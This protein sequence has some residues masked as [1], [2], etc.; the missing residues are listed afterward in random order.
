MSSPELELRSDPDGAKTAGGTLGPCS[1]ARYSV[2]KEESPRATGFSL[3]VD[4]EVH[5]LENIGLRWRRALLGKLYRRGGFF[6][7]LRLDGFKLFFA[8]ELFCNEPI[9]K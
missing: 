4:F 6:F 3:A 9:L 5:I 7:H 1:K 2:A 8:Q